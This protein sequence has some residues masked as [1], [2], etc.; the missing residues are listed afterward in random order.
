[1]LSLTAFFPSQIKNMQVT[2]TKESRSEGKVGIKAYKNYF[3]AGAHWLMLIFILLVN[4]TAQVNKDT[5]AFNSIFT[6]LVISVLY[7]Y[8]IIVFCSPL[9][10]ALK[11]GYLWGTK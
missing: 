9:G 1:M 3:T 11:M 8:C 5:C 2:L 6:V 10:F 7:L 4:I